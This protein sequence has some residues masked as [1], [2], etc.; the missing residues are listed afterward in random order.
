MQMT[1]CVGCNTEV[2]YLN[3]WLIYRQAEERWNPTLETHSLESRNWPWIH[4]TFSE[5]R[6]KE[7]LRVRE[8]IFGKEWEVKAGVCGE[9][10]AVMTVK[11]EP[12]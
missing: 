5:S 7:R 3:K 11:T 9:C 6:S 12:H 10:A 4:N 2:I 8:E 1:A